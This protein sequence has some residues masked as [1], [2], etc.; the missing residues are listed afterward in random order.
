VAVTGMVAAR[1]LV[2][3]VV[4]AAAVCASIPVVVSYRRHAD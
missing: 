1:D 4:T 2:G 3:P